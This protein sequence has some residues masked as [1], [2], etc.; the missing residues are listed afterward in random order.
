MCQLYSVEVW[1]VTLIIM[2]F[3]AIPVTVECVMHHI[4]FEPTKM[5][6]PCKNTNLPPVQ[7]YFDLSNLKMEVATD[8]SLS[9]TGYALLIVDTMDYPLSV[10]STILLFPYIS[11]HCT[12]YI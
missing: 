7:K 1:A 4:N 12:R 3:I 10:S 8:N 9:I 5:F 11:I 6:T 2:A